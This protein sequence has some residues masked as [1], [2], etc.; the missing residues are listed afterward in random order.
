MSCPHK[1]AGCGA[2]GTGRLHTRKATAHTDLTL[3]QTATKTYT[4][5]RIC[6]QQAKQPPA[7]RG[8]EINKKLEAKLGKKRSQTPMCHALIYTTCSSRHYM[9]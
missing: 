2:K 6:A 1:K 5:I 3:C 8:W 7:S 4:V 9:Q